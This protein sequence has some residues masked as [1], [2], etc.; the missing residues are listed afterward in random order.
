MGDN[1]VK[2]RI[3]IN[4]VSTIVEGVWGCGW[5]EYGAQND[6]AVDGVIIM[7]RGEKRPTD[8]GGM[9]FVQVKCGGSGYRKDQV[10]YPDHIGVQLGKE[11]IVKHKARWAKLPGPSVIVFVDDSLSKEAPPAWWAD[12]RDASTFSPT[13]EGMLLIPKTQIFSH[14]T[15]GEFRRLCGTSHID[16][17][18]EKISI[19]RGDVFIPSLGR[20]ESLRNDA[21]EYYKV[22]RSNIVERTNPVLGEVLI[23]R[24]GWKHITRHGRHSER[25][26]QS[27]LL[28]GAAKKAIMESKKIYQLGRAREKAFPDGNT[29]LTD[30]LGIRVNVSFPHRHESIVQVIL[31]RSRLLKPGSASPERQKIW[32][33]S[34][35]ELRRGRSS[36]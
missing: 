2:E 27:W 14:H 11:Y 7:R 33:Y 19:S 18:L 28:L 35:Y 15:K 22:W 10:Q 25:I 4:K 5:Q 26:I 29:E 20:S 32:F 16:R 30:Y 1:R 6:D 24:V 8:T 17:E 34:V 12:L 36:I 21:W 3:G 13:N 23:N 31:K 9:V